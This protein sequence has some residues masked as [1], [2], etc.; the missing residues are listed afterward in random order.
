M[1]E[2]PEPVAEAHELPLGHMRWFPQAG[3]CSALWARMKDLTV[4]AEDG[5][6]AEGARESHTF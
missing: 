1:A 4:L 2:R 3:L 6:R 5:V